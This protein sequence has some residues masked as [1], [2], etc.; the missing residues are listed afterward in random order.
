MIEQNPD[1]QCKKVL[2]AS[3]EEISEVPYYFRADEIS[4][5]LKTNPHSVQRIVEKLQSAGYAASKTALNTSAFKTDASISQ[6]LHV[7]KN[8]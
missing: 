2:D 7:L 1:R 5:K 3:L 6:I 8:N 4:S